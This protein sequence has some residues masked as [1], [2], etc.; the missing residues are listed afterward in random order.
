[1]KTMKLS[2]IKIKDS[3]A[4]S[5]PQIRKIEECRN[6]WNE[7]HEQDRYLV[8]NHKDELIDGYIQYLI[9]KENNV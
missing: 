8:V 7:N 5:N 9:L 6:Y 3:F 4:N 2:D 1:M